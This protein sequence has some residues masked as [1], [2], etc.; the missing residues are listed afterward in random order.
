M[1]DML[2]RIVDDRKHSEA[3]L[4]YITSSHQRNKLSKVI[5]RLYKRTSIGGSLTRSSQGA[6]KDFRALNFFSIVVTMEGRG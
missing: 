5:Q 4:A 1:L 2:E 6:N 3:T